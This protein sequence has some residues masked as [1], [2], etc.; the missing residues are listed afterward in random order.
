M[1]AAPGEQ[2]I[3]HIVENDADMGESIAMTLKS[4]GYATKIHVSAEEF[5]VADVGDDAHCLTIDLLLPGKTGLGLCRDIAARKNACAFL[6]ITGF[7]DVPSAVEAM[8]L[9]AVDYLEKPFSRERLLESVHRAAG[10]ARA[11]EQKL[12]ERSEVASRLSQLTAREMS[13]LDAVCDGLLTKEI[14]KKL[15]ISTRTVDVHRS[16]I[17]RKL[18]IESPSQLAHLIA[19]QRSDTAM[20]DASQPEFGPI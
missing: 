1:R 11:K 9:G 8:R 3:V 15:D 5:I 6:I 2:V 19:M 4:V 12:R 14:A 13:I 17:L 16:R 20:Q 10:I 18:G 7:G